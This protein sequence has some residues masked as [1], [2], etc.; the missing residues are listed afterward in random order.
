MKKLTFL[1]LLCGIALISATAFLA[2][3][4]SGQKSKLRRSPQ[5]AAGQFIILL[6]EEFV[7]RD[8]V[9]PVVEAEAQFL[10]SVYG[11]VV[12]Q[13]YSSV[14]KGY[15]AS[16]SLEQAEALSRDDRVLFVE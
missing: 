9:A 12:R 4:T 13:V 1:S 3:Q 15:V 11:G 7:G 10:S 8:A 16:M 14:F 6:N 5:P 2:T